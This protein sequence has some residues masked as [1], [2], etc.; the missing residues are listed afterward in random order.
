V[1]STAE[2]ARPRAP[3]HGLG[4]GWA[5][6]GARKTANTARRSRGGSSDHNDATSGEVARPFSASTR[7]KERRGAHCLERR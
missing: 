4:C 3:G 1:V 6:R 5:L 7:G 2:L